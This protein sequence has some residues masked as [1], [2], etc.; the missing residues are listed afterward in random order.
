P[1]TARARMARCIYELAVAGQADGA[2]QAGGAGVAN[3]T[4]DTFIHG[5]GSTAAELPSTQGDRL[6]EAMRGP[7]GILHE[8][9]FTNA[10]L[11]ATDILLN[12]RGG[13]QADDIVTDDFYR[14]LGLELLRINA[15]IVA[16]SG[17]PHARA[18]NVTWLNSAAGAATKDEI[19]RATKLVQRF[20]L[21]YP[22]AMRT[23]LE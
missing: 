16:A 9:K 6:L 14:F 4:S 8:R 15:A 2:L 1:A 21:D 3:M 7:R 13:L 22:G 12:R 5:T 18:D 23:L 10:T 20:L 17:V 11:A 19:S